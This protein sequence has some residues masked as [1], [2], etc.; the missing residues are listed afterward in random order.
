M[1]LDLWKLFFE[2]ASAGNITKASERLHISQP[3]ITKQIKKL[4]DDLNCKLFI[5]T[6]KG[7]ILT[8]EGELIFQDIKNGL[9]AFEL[10][11][12]KLNSQN[13]LLQGTIRIGVGTTLT[14]T[15]LMPY[16]NKFHKLYPGIIL[17]ISTDP[18]SVLKES[19]KKGKIDFIIAK[20]PS[21]MND[22]L[23][24][25]KLGDMEDV[26]IVGKTYKELIDKKL[27]LKS[28]ADYPI[29]LQKQPSSSRDNV[30]KYCY[31]NGVKLHSIME[32]A[33]SNLLIEFTKIGYGIGIV[34]KQYIK[35]ELSK[36][37][38]YILDINPKIPK[39]E[40]GIITLKNNYLS[41][42]SSIFIDLLIKNTNKEYD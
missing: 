35:N 39:R 38:V 31:E 22:D 28:I 26:F 11:E 30:E 29:L 42:A 40:F 3:A 33:S 36:K 12:K 17:E 1:N 15:F 34:T 37:E 23:G 25:Q 32:I 18:T 24:Y 8:S 5:R 19:L 7:V 41:K 20:F 4:E 16:I 14:K 6:Q 2:V 27:N 10:A 9:N 21:K 13:L